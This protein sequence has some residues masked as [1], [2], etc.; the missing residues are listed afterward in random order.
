M[1]MGTIDWVAYVLLVIGGLNWGLVG[2]F[3]FNLVGTLFG[4]G[5]FT[6]IIYD[7]VG[8]SALWSIYTMAR[9]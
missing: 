9:S 7:L 6:D 8:L 1:K 4:A 5:T 3:D 2:F